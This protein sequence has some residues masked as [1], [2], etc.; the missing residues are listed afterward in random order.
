MLTHRLPYPPDRGDRIR[1]YHLLQHL[2]SRYTVSLASLSHEPVTDQQRDRLRALVGDR[3][4]I[5]RI[6][7]RRAKL[8]GG[9]KALLRRSAITPEVFWHPAL[10]KR[11]DQWQAARPFDIVLT[12]CTGMTQ[13]S[14]Q[15]CQQN[16]TTRH[17]LDLVDIDSAKWQA[18]SEK[19]SSNLAMRWIYQREAKQLQRIEA[20]TSPMT[21]SRVD[22]LSVI[23][24]REAAT[25]RQTVSDQHENKLHVIGNGVDLN[26]YHP[27]IRSE[28]H[29]NKTKT[30][31]FVGVLDYQPNI[32]AMTWFV[33]EVL[34]ALNRKMNQPTELLMVGRNPSEKIRQLAARPD[35][36][37][38]ANVPDV[39]PHL[40]AADMVIAPLAVAPGVQNKVLEAMACGKAVVCSPSAAAGIDA[41]A[42]QDVA[43][44]REHQA[45]NYIEAISSLLK[46]DVE[47]TKIERAA[48]QCVE[49]RYSWNAAVEPMM[50]LVERLACERRA[51]CQQNMKLPRDRQ[52]IGHQNTIS[53]NERVTRRAA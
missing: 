11:I 47:R 49:T 21:H 43:V 31:A 24:E 2:A 15:V 44:T 51:A 48:R 35:V 34:P 52:R 25:Y 26:F 39:R 3:L 10:A 4:A 53:V 18:L 20:L 5:Q 1:S 29:A 16:P 9:F 42:G 38:A 32:D 30:L 40:W 36:R 6:D 19:P 45:L 7:L 13:Y 12:F 14:R 41:K 22:A 23:S 50:D 33:D 17:I 8:K 46:D 37:L 27:Q 28:N